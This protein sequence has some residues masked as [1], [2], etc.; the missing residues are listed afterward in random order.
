MNKFWMVYVEGAGVPKKLYSD[1]SEA[2]EE[3]ER[4]CRKEDKQVAL[5]E[6]INYVQMDKTVIP[7]RW[8][9]WR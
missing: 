4:L 7:V 1:I 2:K 8:N 6:C 3:A 5:L 9:I